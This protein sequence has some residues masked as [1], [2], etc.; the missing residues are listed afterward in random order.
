MNN[1]KKDYKNARRCINGTDRMD[2]I[3]NYAEEF[4]RILLLAK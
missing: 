1:S 2:L 4:E 3:A